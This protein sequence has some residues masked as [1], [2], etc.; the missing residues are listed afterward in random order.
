MSSVNR[1]RFS[2]VHMNAPSYG[3]FLSLRLAL[4]LLCVGCR[5]TLSSALFGCLI[6][7]Y[8]FVLYLTRV[9]T[10]MLHSLSL[11]LCLCSE[12]KREMTGKRESEFC[13]EQN[14]YVYSLGSLVYKL[15]WR[16]MA[17]TPYAMSEREAHE[18][19]NTVRTCGEFSTTAACEQRSIHMFKY[20][21]VFIHSLAFALPA[22]V[23][24]VCEH[25]LH[26]L[27]LR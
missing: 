22:T 6:H 12:S 19:G 21:D 10:E 15:F 24:A 8:R 25:S 7:A 4:S 18:R 5:A 3:I 2:F 16:R 26:R 14:V 17:L 11:V 23:G 20:I 9:T 27:H 1:V 13:M